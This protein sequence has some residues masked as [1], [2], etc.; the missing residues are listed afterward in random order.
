MPPR[1]LPEQ[2]IRRRLRALG[3]SL[4]KAVEGDAR[5]IHK[6]RVASRRVREALPIV[7]ASA[8]G[9]K[10][11]KLRTRVERVTRALGPVRETDVSLALIDELATPDTVLGWDVVRQRLQ[12]E[13]RRRH[14]RLVSKLE[15]F[16]AR[17][18]QTRTARLIVREPEPDGM[19][20]R[21]P[22]TAVL[23][24]RLT[25]RVQEL[26]EAVHGAGPLY[27]PEPIHGVRIAVK[28]LRYAF[29]LARDLKLLSAPRV[30][31]GLR[32]TQRT[33]G[34]LHD[35][36][37][38]SAHVAACRAEVPASAEQADML[39]I[40]T[41]RLDEE[42]RRLHA[43]FVARREKL[44]AVADEA[45]ADVAERAASVAEDADKATVH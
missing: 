17:R 26:D 24:L 29:E 38:L 3:R 25:K 2:V 20:Q 39:D 14:Q 28:K 19:E 44:L 43:R 21:L 30:L 31:T 12:I 23:V 22:G 33:L 8:P 4:P 37:V 35:L 5:A 16:D 15:D 40:I 6:A 45:L 27:A 41:A 13:R 10:S 9:K 7:L 36:Q 11:R 34:R 1:S 32:N 42:C 18:V